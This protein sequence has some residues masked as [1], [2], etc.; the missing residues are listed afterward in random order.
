MGTLRSLRTGDFALDNQIALGTQK[1][2][3]RIE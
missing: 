3:E 2:L 1:P